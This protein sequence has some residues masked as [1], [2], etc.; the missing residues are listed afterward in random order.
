MRQPKFIYTEAQEEALEGLV[1]LGFCR[2]KSLASQAQIDL[3]W[4][5]VPVEQGGG[6]GLG[7]DHN[8]VAA[9]VT[10]KARTIMDKDA[11]MSR[12]HQW[13]ADHN[14]DVPVPY[15]KL[16]TVKR[17]NW[18]SA[19]DRKILQNLTILGLC[20]FNTRASIQVKHV[21]L[22]IPVEQLGGQGLELQVKQVMGWLKNLY[23]HGEK[24]TGD[25]DASMSKWEKW[26]SDHNQLVPPYKYQDGT[27]SRE[28]HTISMT[29]PKR[30][31]DLIDANGHEDSDSPLTDLSDLEVD[32]SSP[33]PSHQVTSKVES[34]SRAL[35][36]AARTPAEKKTRVG[37]EKNIAITPATSA[38]HLRNRTALAT[39]KNIRYVGYNT[40]SDA[41]GNED[42][43]DDETTKPQ[44]NNKTPTRN[45]RSKPLAFASKTPANNRGNKVNNKQ[46]PSTRATWNPLN[47]ASTYGAD[48]D[49]ASQEESKNDS[50]T[51][52]ALVTDNTAC[53]TDQG[54]SIV[55]QFP[56]EVSS[57]PCAQSRVAR[58]ALD[59]TA[60]SATELNSQQR[61]AL[62]AL[63]RLGLYRLTQ[64][65]MQQI[66]QVWRKVSPV[67]GGGKGLNITRPQ[68]QRFFRE[69]GLD[70]RAS[71]VRQNALSRWEEWINTHRGRV[72][73]TRS[74]S[75][76][77]QTS[78]AS[79]QLATPTLG[80]S[81]I[82]DT[83]DI[84][85][86][87]LPSKKRRYYDDESKDEDNAYTGCESPRAK[88]FKQSGLDSCSNAALDQSNSPRNSSSINNAPASHPPRPMPEYY[89]P[90]L[91]SLYQ[92][93]LELTEEQINRLA[94]LV[95]LG[96]CWSITRDNHLIEKIWMRVPQKFGGGLGLGVPFNIVKT[97]VRSRGENGFRT[98]KGLARWEKWIARNRSN[99]VVE[100]N[101]PQVMNKLSGM[102]VEGDTLMSDDNMEERGGGRAARIVDPYV[103]YV[104]SLVAENLAS[105]APRTM[106]DVAVGGLGNAGNQERQP[107]SPQEQTEALPGE[108]E[109]RKAPQVQSVDAP[110][111]SLVT[112][113][114]GM[115]PAVETTSNAQ[116][117][118]AITQDIV[119]YLNLLLPPAATTPQTLSLDDITR[120]AVTNWNQLSSSHGNLG[121]IPAQTAPYI[122]ACQQQRRC[123][124]TQHRIGTIQAGITDE[125]SASS[126]V[127]QVTP[128]EVPTLPIP[129][130]SRGACIS[131]TI[132]D[133]AGQPPAH[134]RN[135]ERNPW[136]RE[137][138]SV[139]DWY[140]YPP[141]ALGGPEGRLF[142]HWSSASVPLRQFDSV[143]THEVTLTIG[144][145]PGSIGRLLRGLE[146]WPEVKQVMFHGYQP[147]VS[148]GEQ[149]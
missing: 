43:S 120:A 78:M 128:R 41:S 143:Q 131:Q 138:G 36:P 72:R 100:E 26:I 144:R 27:W 13:V 25:R 50:S 64:R 114:N 35:L 123:S 31:Q 21:W 84:S 86:L 101:L 63:A 59:A 75:T 81:C 127:L 87:E 68:I 136:L 46:G 49:R 33:V 55:L 74:Q 99:V 137:D 145:D 149:K 129:Q 57:T 6:M 42:S 54:E 148:S 117:V 2:P 10:N 56:A 88:R 115:L 40:D 125:R 93:Y 106:R 30:A 38:Y 67:D 62:D 113:Q 76:N 130:Q 85:D 48:D 60:L 95:R 146:Q 116:E 107:E 28:N 135:A 45:A 118:F 14:Q 133:L 7:L 16:E 77:S 12:W 141:G 11:A 32:S 20:R 1:A 105:S 92:P 71:D 65:A 69:N 44:P 39:M 103:D 121:A 8:A 126:P 140:W 79:S 90:R 52:N 109:F 104:T 102:D 19:E 91:Q 29:T 22:E 53:R 124:M 80:T 23:S 98:D 17:S 94:Q 37:T 34:K 9:F 96:G 112:Q 3:V 18:F 73:M 142:E 147:Q 89:D 110:T 83:K 5:H 111:Q 134:P 58:E 15:I 70:E 24:F 108:L 122:T 4:L 119:S 61:Y 51:G 47:N 132:I 66:W 82:E 97:F 139:R